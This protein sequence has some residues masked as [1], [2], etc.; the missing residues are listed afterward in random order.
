VLP[1]IDIQ[2]TNGAWPP[3][4]QLAKLVHEAVE[5]AVMATPLAFRPGSEL[6]LVFSD[7]PTIRALNH[8]WRGK[9]KATNV[10]SFPAGK[11]IL[12]ELPGPLL[13]DIVLAFET[14]KN[15]AELEDKPF[16]HHLQ[17][18]VIH[19]FFHLFGYDHQIDAEAETMENLE[20]RALA[21][22]GIDDPYT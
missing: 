11:A 2:V 20:R 8:Q 21:Q 14:I 18:L 3:E 1:E 17:H 12:D 13:G 5:A 10:L 15:E 16:E 6:C 22:L 19:G 9:D 7:D 4:E